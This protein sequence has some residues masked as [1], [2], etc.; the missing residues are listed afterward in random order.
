MGLPWVRL[1][2]NIASHDKIL[3]LLEMRD[4]VKAA[5][6]Y[7]CSLGYSGGHDT[8]GLIRFAVLSHIHGTKKLAEMAVEVELWAPDPEGWRI[9][10]WAT[11]QQT[12]ATT[13]KKRSAQS[14]GAQRGNCIRWHGPECGC[15]D[16][17]GTENNRV[18]QLSQLPGQLTDSYVLTN[19]L[20]N[21]DQFSP[22]IENSLSER[23]RATPRIGGVA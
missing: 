20:T 21:L 7:V 2:S 9:P 3:D 11:R 10:K 12:T 19:E 1:D 5:W 18:S 16:D 8:D 17:T 13:E 14:K 23:A 6:M 22:S 15:W 4:G